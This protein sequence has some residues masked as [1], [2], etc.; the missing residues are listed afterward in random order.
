[1][2][3]GL[4]RETFVKQF[5]GNLYYQIVIVPII[6]FIFVL[7]QAIIWPGYV[8][9]NDTSCPRR[10]GPQV[11]D[12]VTIS[13]VSVIYTYIAILCMIILLS[14]GSWMKRAFRNKVA[15]ISGL[16]LM[17][18]SVCLMVAPAVYRG[19]VL[20]YRSV[21]P[22]MFNVTR[23]SATKATVNV[24]NLWNQHL[25]DEQYVLMEVRRVSS[26]TRDIVDIHPLPEPIFKDHHFSEASKVQ[27]FGN[28][29]R[30]I[31]G[32][33]DDGYYLFV[34][35]PAHEAVG[36]ASVGSYIKHVS[37]ITV[38]LH[39]KTYNS[40]YIDVRAYSICQWDSEVGCQPIVH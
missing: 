33:E 28:V 16:I 39:Q 17:A 34:I 26:N 18:C 21:Q 40:I 35:I 15:S 25:L 10:K 5:N 2:K 32:L 12:A 30:S 8:F 36:R 31:S 9:C 4:W 24:Y 22:Y 11:P 27:P 1:M 13:V 3:D 7:V 20:S 6:P 19:Y 23:E 14:S 29:S 37:S 38:P